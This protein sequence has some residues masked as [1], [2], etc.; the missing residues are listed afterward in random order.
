M[1]TAHVLEEVHANLR[2]MTE[3]AA[4]KGASSWLTALPGEEHGS[5]LNKTVFWDAIHMR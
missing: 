3:L 4:E 2:R 1:A 5:Y